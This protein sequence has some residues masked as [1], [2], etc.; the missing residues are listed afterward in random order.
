MRLRS[1]QL[2]IPVHHQIFHLGAT[3]H[4]GSSAKK[5]I[6]SLRN[7]LVKLLRPSSQLML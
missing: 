6:A 3:R 1:I 7:A 4:L 5:R 2:N